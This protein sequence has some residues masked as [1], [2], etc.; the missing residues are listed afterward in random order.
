MNLW[1]CIYLHFGIA[2]SIKLLME[3][4]AVSKCIHNG[5]NTEETNSD[6]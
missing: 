3:T 5:S 4:K 6:C 2:I 1:L